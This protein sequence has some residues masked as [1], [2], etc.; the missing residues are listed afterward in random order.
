MCFF[1][2]LLGALG[3]GGAGAGAAGAAGAVS[4]GLSIGSIFKIGA[5]IFSAV[6]KISQ[7]H[8]A[9]KAAEETARQQDQAALDA[10]EQGKD[11]SD[12][13]RRAGAI[14]AS[15]QQAGLAANGIDVSGPL[16]LDLLNESFEVTGSDAFAIRENAVRRGRQFAQQAA[17]SRTEARSIRSQALFG[18]VGS[19]LTTASKVGPKFTSTQAFK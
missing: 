17:N 16:G 7:A 11:E 10:I 2:P 5:G 3:I 19:L 13:R 18:A 6:S 9:A 4:G 14:E 15:R 1:A 8:A 12:R